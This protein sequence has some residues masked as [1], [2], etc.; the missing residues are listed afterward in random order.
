MNLISRL[1]I[2]YRNEP[3]NIQYKS[4]NL[5]IILLIIGIATT[6]MSLIH[7]I[8]G[9]WM[10]LF[11]SSL[12]AMAVSAGGIIILGRGKY[13]LASTVSLLFL[14]LTPL[15]TMMVQSV[16]GYRDIYM[17]FFFS[18]PVLI[19][20]IIVGYR[21]WQLWLIT[22]IELLGALVYLMLKLLP[23]IA[24]AK[25]DMITGIIFSLIFF[26]LSVSILAVSFKV[27][28]KIMLRLQKNTDK[29]KERENRLN[30]LLGS[31][32]SMLS[33]GEEL[34]S[35]AM[36]SSKKSKDIELSVEEIQLKMNELKEVI[37]RSNQDQ[38]NLEDGGGRINEVM[39]KQT[40]AVNQSASSVE[41]MTASLQEI[42]KSAMEKSK[43]IEVLSKKS[44]ETEDSFDRTKKS[45]SSLEDSS[46]KVLEVL[47]VIEG[48]AT[49]TNLLAMNAAI[50]AAHA[51]N[52]GRG[53]AVVA[54]EIRKLAEQTNL[55]A[56]LTRD[57]LAK[58]N[59]DIQEVLEAH[60]INRQHFEEINSHTFEMKSA[61]EEMIG[62]LGEVS[63]G[64]GEINRILGDLRSI[65][66]T[67]S[68]TVKEI[69][70]IIENNSQNSTKI[71]TASQVVEQSNLG[72]KDLGH[73]LK[74]LSEELLSIGS[75]NV[76]NIQ[77]LN[78]KIDELEME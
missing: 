45:L 12:P 51:G 55:N 60:R 68:T 43:S 30:E 41:Q 59:Q 70:K 22:L 40:D 57:I 66:E 9:R 34:S 77:Q 17:Y 27:E 3:I 52:S 29:S 35:I 42:T 63:Q 38:K 62:G 24:G 58:N 53:F 7:I 1:T 67:V 71:N 18:V 64:T 73:Q 21:R 65:N 75:K 31:S 5:I 74:I 47:D 61:L 32:K 15:G 49:G 16:S 76:E 8:T 4:R 2:P 48:I 78:S 44:K 19:L 36:N 23:E 69:N 50:E 37:Q 13:F 14:A 26:A 25:S 39:N 54:Q 11:S 33:I 20:S 10:T 46:K 56:K 6:L 72:I 28:E